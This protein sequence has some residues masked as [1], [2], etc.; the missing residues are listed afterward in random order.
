MAARVWIQRDL[1]NVNVLS[2]GKDRI[3]RQVIFHHVVLKEN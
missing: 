2:V 1:T 3:V